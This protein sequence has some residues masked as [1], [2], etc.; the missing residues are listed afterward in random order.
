MIAH[1]LQPREIIPQHA[2]NLSSAGSSS[3]TVTIVSG[4]TKRARSSTW[5]SV[6]SPA[7]PSPSQS[8]LL[9]AEIDAQVFFDFRA[10]QRRITIAD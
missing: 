2:G 9:D 10:A 1:R 7:M 8:T 6:S 5:P 4:L 3:I